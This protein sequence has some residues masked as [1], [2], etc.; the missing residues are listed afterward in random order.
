MPNAATV[1][2]S[3]VEYLVGAL[4]GRGWVVRHHVSRWLDWS[5]RK[6]RI[7]AQASGGRVIGGQ[8]GY[9]LSTEAT[10]AEA[11]HAVASMRSRAREIAH[12]ADEIEACATG[13]PAEGRLF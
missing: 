10:A 4:R 7:A 6:L 2:A 1:S 5:D 3:E 11:D 8:R 12:R 9:R 13:A